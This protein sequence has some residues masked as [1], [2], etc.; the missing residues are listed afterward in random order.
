MA[1]FEIRSDLAI[2]VG[3]S[4]TAWAKLLTFGN[5]VTCY[6]EL[7]LLVGPIERLVRSMSVERCETGKLFEFA[8]LQRYA[9]FSF[10]SRRRSYLLGSQA[11]CRLLELGE[12]FELKW[13]AVGVVT[14][15]VAAHAFESQCVAGAEGRH[16]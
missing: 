7:S 9:R 1:S 15:Y 2:F 6:L 13:Q 4:L 3:V 14:R 12:R 11:R 8:G 16:T 5:H 10:S